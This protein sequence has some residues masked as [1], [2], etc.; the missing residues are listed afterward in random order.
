MKSKQLIFFLIILIFS[1]FGA[2]ALFQSAQLYSSHDIWHNVARFYHYNQALNDGQIL[3]TWI[4]NMAKGFGYPLFYFSYHVPWLVGEL[5][6]KLNFDFFTAFKMVY[7]VGFFFSGISMYLLSKKVFKNNLA[8]LLTSILYL[9]APF[10][11]LCMFVSA[12]VGMVWVFAFTPLIFLAIWNMHYSKSNKAIALFAL[13]YSGAVLSHFMTTVMLTPFILLFFLCLLID[14]FKKQKNFQPLIKLFFAISLSLMISGFYLLPLI[15]F[16]KEIQATYQQ[17]AFKSI[18]KSNFVNLD[19]LV[20]S[21][22]GFGPIIS[23]AKDGEISFQIGIAQ[24]LSFL[25]ASILLLMLKLKKEKVEKTT[26]FYSLVVMFGTSIFLMLDSSKILWQIANKFTTLDYPFRLILPAVFFS[27][28]MAGFIIQNIKNKYIKLLL[29]SFF[30]VLAVYTNRNHIKV[31]MYTDFTLED[32]VDAETTTNTYHEYLPY[33]ATDQLFRDDFNENEKKSYQIERLDD[34]T[35][36]VN[37]RISN[38]TAQI[39]S[40]PQ[41]NFPGQVVFDKNQNT[42]EHQTDNVGRIAVILDSGDHYLTVSYK[43]PMVV[44]FAYS[45]SILGLLIINYL[46]LKKENK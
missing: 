25:L 13:S 39:V 44:K 30:I 9:W 15:S 18:Y 33:K 29:A 23:N 31:N 12:S 45:I 11:F 14:N 36:R 1:F 6:L 42:I 43:K 24:W 8:S 16:L 28:L 10:Q 20:Y 7:F 46:Y 17:D 2:R 41:F 5:F 38:P 26:F 27:S 19:Q 21:K 32:Y 22:W 35:T 37:L 4:S 34:D 40:L 3:P